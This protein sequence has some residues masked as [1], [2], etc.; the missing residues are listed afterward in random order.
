MCLVSILGQF[1]VCELEVSLD[2]QPNDVYKLSPPLGWSDGM[3]D[4][5]A[6]YIN[7]MYQFH[8]LYAASLTF[9]KAGHKLGGSHDYR[10]VQKSSGTSQ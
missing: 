4:R 5:D 10:N 1:V 6:S 2:T 3:R 9:I 7:T 8:S